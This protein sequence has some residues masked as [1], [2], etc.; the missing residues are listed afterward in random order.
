MKTK[1]FIIAAVISIVFVSCKNNQETEKKEE[2]PKVAVKENFSVDF[3][4]IAPKAD[5]FAVYYTE[6][7]T[8]NFSGENALWRGVLAQPNKVQTVTVDFPKDIVPTNIRFDFGN[9]KQQDDLILQKFKLSYYGKNF[10]AQGSDFFKYFA[11]ND[12][13]K[14]QINP[15]NGTITFLKN[16]NS[17]PYYFPN[18]PLL[19]EISRITK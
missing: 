8:I 12:S 3:E 1:N 6:D 2:T 14:T 13:I 4:V 11:Q 10:E 19:D 16:I 7:G 5:D 15:A 18:K 17:V 9:S